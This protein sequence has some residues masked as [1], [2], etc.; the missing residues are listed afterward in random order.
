MRTRIR[1]WSNRYGRRFRP[2]FPVELRLESPAAPSP[3]YGGEVTKAAQIFD[4]GDRGS[5]RHG[6]EA[7][8]VNGHNVEWQQMSFNGANG[9]SD[10]AGK[11]AREAVRADG[12]KRDTIERHRRLKRQIA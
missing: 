6:R 9:M 2:T 11:A 7:R 12:S 5:G 4:N 10:M 3:A 8:R 1:I